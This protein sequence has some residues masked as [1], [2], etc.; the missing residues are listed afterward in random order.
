MGHAVDGVSATRG[1]A[2]DW[3]IAT[4]MRLRHALLT[5]VVFPT[6][7][8]AQSPHSDI[9]AALQ[10]GQAWRATQ[11]VAPLLTRPETRTPEVLLLGARAAAAWEGWTTVRSLLEREPWL[12]TRFDRLGRRLLA[13]AALG[14]QRNT[15]ALAAAWASVVDGN[16]RDNA[17]QGLRWV[18]LARAHDRLDQRDSAA[19][20]YQH[21]AALL[22]EAAEW[23]ALRAAGVTTDSASRHALYE[24]VTS[25]PATPRIAW[26]EAQALERAGN[27]V[28]AADAYQRLGSGATALRLRWQ[29]ATSDAEKRVVADA[30]VAQLRPG[31]ST[32]GARDALIL[33]ERLPVPV[34]P[35][36]RLLVARRAAQVGR[37]AQAADAFAAS[38]RLGRLTPADRFAYGN[39]LTNLERWPDAA[40][41]FRGVTDPVLGGHAAYFHA[42][43]MLRAGKGAE[44]VNALERVVTGFPRDTVAAGTALFLLG[45][46]A[47]D[48]GDAAAAQ[49]WFSLLGSRYPSSAVA[50]RA[51]LLA[52]LIR[53]A[54]GDATTA[55]R[56][57]SRNT[58]TYAASGEADAFRYWLGRARRVTGQRSS[59]DSIFRILLGRGP[60]SYYAIRAAARLDTL[61]WSVGQVE[62]SGRDT[63][64]VVI[65]RVVLLERLGLD[66]EARFELDFLAASAMTPDARITMAE[67]MLAHG[68]TARAM[69]LGQRALATGAARDTRT[70]RLIYPLPWADALRVAGKAE[71][72]DALLAASVIRQESGF[73]PH[74]TSR[75]DARGLMQI[76]PAVGRELGRS[77]GF[78]DLDPALLWQPEVN[79]PLGMRHFGNA[80]K[81]Y[82]EPERA[83][84]A[85][86]A[87]QS[88]VN[89]WSATLLGGPRG[90]AVTAPIDDIELFVER[91]PYVETRD[92]VR[93]VMRNV[94][95]YR[96]LHVGV[97]R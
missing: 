50:P 55:E 73:Q 67:R 80:L 34:T 64:D 22:P 74:A 90:G 71:G 56:D 57:L 63:L 2:R 69:Q 23:L 87:G 28:R 10:A 81:R 6:A 29:G 85:Y 11:L 86:N 25:G 72:V 44:A 60:E 27:L 8:C 5:L 61:P 49:R 7:M 46:L 96:M 18:L 91:I 17:E 21:A 93:I 95:M 51:A 84:A 13:E 12:D 76:M 45:D 53:M 9:E 38:A 4:N 48:A 14:A 32:A 97:A 66:V 78:S 83:L 52:A 36:Q 59:A 54:T 15:D 16:E 43:A 39:V 40:V 19:A 20:A 58:V 24:T 30:L 62:A 79:I 94:A 75:T 65:S 41:Q 31:L 33:I 1:R 42:R 47:I 70:L 88:R 89:R 35:A 3:S 77:F 26:T 68:Y 92:Y 82:P 37:A